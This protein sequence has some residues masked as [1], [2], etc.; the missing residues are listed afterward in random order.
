MQVASFNIHS[1]PRSV[2]TW[3]TPSPVGYADNRWRQNRWATC[4]VSQLPRGT[5]RNANLLNITALCNC[6][7]QMFQM[8][9]TIFIRPVRRLEPIAE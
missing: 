3:A 2:L 1:K 8:S 5:V 7:E 4:C 6:F 9:V